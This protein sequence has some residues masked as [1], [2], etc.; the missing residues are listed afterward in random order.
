MTSFEEELIQDLEE[1]IAK[2]IEYDDDE[3]DCNWGT[4]RRSAYFKKTG[5]ALT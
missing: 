3:D 2:L 5:R 4:S 1:Q